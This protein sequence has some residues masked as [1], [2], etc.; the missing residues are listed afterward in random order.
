ME[1]AV[2]EASE[3]IADLHRPLTPQ[4]D[5]AASLSHVEHPMIYNDYTFSFAGRKYQMVR[6][7]VVAG[8]KRQRI[9]VELR[10]DGSIQARYEGKYVSIKEC[11]AGA[12]TQPSV[13][14]TPVRKEHN[15]GGRSR[16]M[17][18]FW[19]QKQTP[20]LWRAIRDSNAHT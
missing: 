3:G 2:R 8:M 20:A 18:D 15:A 10:L 4:I 5:L 1:R 9:R 13:R 17:S 19:N 12:E 16:W 11:I 6:E 7:A 14:K